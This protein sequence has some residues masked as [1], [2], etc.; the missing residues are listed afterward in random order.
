MRTFFKD[1]RLSLN[2]YGRAFKFIFDKGLAVYF[3]FPFVFV[4]IIFFG[5]YAIIDQ[6]TSATELWFKELIAIDSWTFAGA[7]YIGTAIFWLIW[8]VFKILFFVVFRFVGGTIVLVLMSPVLAHLSERTERIITGR[9]YPF[10]MDQ[11]MRDAVRGVVI[12]TRNFGFEL[13][14]IVLFFLIGFIPIIGIISPFAL[15]IVMA[16]FYGFSFMDYTNE[17]QRMSMGE[18]SRFI[19][20]H[21]GVAIGNGS[22]YALILLIPFCGTYL[23]GFASILA[24]VA[25]TMATLETDEYK[26]IDTEL[27]QRAAIENE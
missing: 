4:L 26:Q 23:A 24:V 11:L 25:A 2:A 20:K 14:F 22:I 17:R 9:E 12:A 16:F 1:L 7:E 6:F 5:G 19:K 15:F 3:L 21:K 13:I 27:N 10:T 8:F 18:S